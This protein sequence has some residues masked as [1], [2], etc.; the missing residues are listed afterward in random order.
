MF[1]DKNIY[2]L[3]LH[4]CLVVD[5]SLK[6]RRVPGG[7]NYEYL[8]GQ[9]VSVQFVSLNKEFQLK[10]A[11]SPKI[12]KTKSP[13]DW[14]KFLHL[15]NSI[16]AI[17]C[18]SITDDIKKLYAISEKKYTKEG[19]CTSIINYGKV[20]NSETK[21]FF[22]TKWSLSTFLKQS[23]CIPNFL[24]DGE[25]WVNYKNSQSSKEYSSGVAGPGITLRT[26]D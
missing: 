17:R 14:N 26:I 10:S 13:I 25:T 11:P 4:E 23:N 8:I 1:Q 12:L 3:S 18:N 15:W 22:D 5:E 24:S 20:L 21:Y 19:I 7:W 16:N 2:D 9:E 6:I